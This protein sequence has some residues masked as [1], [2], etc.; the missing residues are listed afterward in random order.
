MLLFHKL[1]RTTW[2]S[3]VSVSDESLSVGGRLSATRSN[4]RQTTIL[5]YPLNINKAQLVSSSSSSSSICS[6][7]K[8]QYVDV[9]HN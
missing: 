7:A 4:Q 5:L 1:G 3:R 8:I 9:V 6:E 2:S